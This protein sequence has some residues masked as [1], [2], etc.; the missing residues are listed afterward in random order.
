MVRRA[1]AP[2][3]DINLEAAAY[4]QTAEKALKSLLVHLGIAYPRGR[5]DGHDINVIAAKIPASHTL[6]TD[7]QA[8]VPL[9]PR[10]TAYHYP[11]DDRFRRRTFHWHPKSLT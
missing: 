1:L 3:P 4:Q 11:A 7:A 2:M 5:G 10:A 6:Y 9:T 8:L